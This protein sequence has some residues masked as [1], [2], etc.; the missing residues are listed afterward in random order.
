MNGEINVKL[1]LCSSCV[2]MRGIEKLW[3]IVVVVGGEKW[4]RYINFF[5]VLNDYILVISLLYIK[6]Y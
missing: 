3:I 2:V 6:S 4:V 1:F 5:K